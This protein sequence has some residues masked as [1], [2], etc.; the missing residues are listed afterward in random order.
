VVEMLAKFGILPKLDMVLLKLV[1]G[2]CGYIMDQ[3]GIM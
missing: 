2:I 1:V 3:I